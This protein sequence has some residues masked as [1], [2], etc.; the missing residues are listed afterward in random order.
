MKA[1]L[2]ER[3][4]YERPMAAQGLV[5]Y[6]YKGPYNWIMIGARDIRDA[7][8]EANRSLTYGR[9]VIEN[10]EIWNNETNEYEKAFVVTSKNNA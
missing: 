4:L 6:R 5:S 3:P 9:A 7:L 1:L 10:L 2:Y 8:H